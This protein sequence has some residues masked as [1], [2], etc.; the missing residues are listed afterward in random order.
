MNLT[1]AQAREIT[2][3]SKVENIY[4]MIHHRAQ[5][6]KTFILFDFLTEIAFKHLIGNGYK[7]YAEDGCEELT[8]Y[9]PELFVGRN[10]M[11]DWEDARC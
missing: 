8:Q 2:E 6:G 10:I 1:A 5:E 9:H 4:S 3:N 7:V 11:I